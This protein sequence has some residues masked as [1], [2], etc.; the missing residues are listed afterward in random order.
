MPRCVAV[1]RRGKEGAKTGAFGVIGSTV[2]S[3]DRYRVE[4]AE[5][6]ATPLDA[7]NADAGGGNAIPAFYAALGPL[8]ALTK[9]VTM[10]DDPR[11]WQVEVKYG[12]AIPGTEP[13]PATPDPAGERWAINISVAAVPFEVE[14]QRDINGDMIE[15]TAGDPVTGIT[16][17]QSD[18]EILISFTTNVVD[19]DGID[20][21]YGASGRGA[22]NS[23]DVTMTINGQSRTFLARTL[24]FIEYSENV[25]VDPS[26]VAYIKIIYKLRWRPSNWLRKI[27][28]KGLNQLAYHDEIGENV[29]EPIKIQGNVIQS[30]VYLTTDEFSGQVFRAN[31]GDDVE[32]IGP[33]QT[34]AAPGSGVQITEEV[35]LGTVLL[36]DI[37]S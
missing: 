12:V 30:P 4:F 17:P 21:A 27:A 6:T 11:M 10:L 34:V 1:T 22:I 14:I 33:G 13:A 35:D 37:G 36:W 3:V 31:P 28:N 18:E 2:E 9:T 20:A 29:L 32:I 15:N 16:E 19:Y 5:P 8:K 23:V 24:R 7:A 26:G 25:T